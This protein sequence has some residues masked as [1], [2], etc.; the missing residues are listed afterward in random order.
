V[1][2][3]VPGR[4]EAAVVLVAN[5]RTESLLPV[6][7]L[8]E[9]RRLSDIGVS[10]KAEPVRESRNTG[11]NSDAVCRL[12][13]VGR[14]VPLKGIDLLLRAF[15]EVVATRPEAELEIVGDGPQRTEL[16]QL[17]A[18][19]G[20]TDQ[21]IFRGWLDPAGCADALERCDVFVFP[22]LQEA[23]G[24]AVLEA[25]AAARP[26]IAARWGGPAELLDDD[27]AILV[28]VDSVPEFGK[29][30]VA[31]MLTLSAEPSRRRILGHSGRRRVEREFDWE[32]LIDRALQLYEELSDSPEVWAS[33][34][35]RVTIVGK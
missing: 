14:L 12:C 8:G 17:T 27:C 26:V 25:M 35:R 4:L 28:S 33:S 18:A 16:E 1:N 29:G 21:V 23:G 32:I 20:L 5:E 13:F 7:L 24:V 22:S 6:G 10:I 2:R 34:S 30:L 19:L 31:A 9:V 15:A 11:E 3:L